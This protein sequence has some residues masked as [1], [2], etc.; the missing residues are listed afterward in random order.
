MN[1]HQLNLLCSRGD[2]SDYRMPYTRHRWA[3]ERRRIVMMMRVVYGSLA[4]VCAFRPDVR[5]SQ[6]RSCWRLE[7]RGGI[8]HHDH[9]TGKLC[10]RYSQKFSAARQTDGHDDR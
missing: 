1:G 2:S 9:G 7:I 5:P 8:A 4:G 10:D 6:G 3:Y